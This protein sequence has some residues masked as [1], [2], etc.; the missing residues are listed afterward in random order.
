MALR[1]VFPRPAIWVATAFL[2]YPIGAQA[3]AASDWIT[4]NKDY[5]SQRYVDLDQITPANVGSLKEVCEIQLNELSWSSTGLLMVGR[6]LYLGT[7]RATYAIDPATCDLRW[8]ELIELKEPTLLTSRGAGYLD[9]MIFRGTMDGRVI[10]LNAET[11]K[12]IWDVQNADPARHEA[13][14]SAPIAWDGKVFI[15][16][17]VS[18]AGIRGRLMALDARTV[19]E[20]W[21][22][23]TI[24]TGNEP[25][26]DTWENKGEIPPAGGGFW[27]TYSL[28]PTNGEPIHTPTTRG[29][30]QATTS[31]PIPSFQ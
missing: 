25:G 15:G 8:R 18:D 20:I 7:G 21:R 10:A 11:G 12:T 24:P 28:A 1:V 19:R 5:S 26:A 4:V 13:F 9:G 31:I 14:T 27:S 30:A 23:Y 16:I 2:A 22:F 17:G 6:T 29:S 3:D